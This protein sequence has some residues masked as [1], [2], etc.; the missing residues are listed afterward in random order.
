MNAQQV[1]AL[2]RRTLELE[3]NKMLHENKWFSISIIDKL[4]EAQDESWSQLIGTRKDAY[5]CLHNLHCTHY[6]TMPQ[7][8]LQS[9]PALIE[10]VFMK[11]DRFAVQEPYTIERTTEQPKTT[12]IRLFSRYS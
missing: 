11:V 7:D 12:R 1:K 2:L 3:F 6:D 5:Q 9:L 4:L 8:I 10:V